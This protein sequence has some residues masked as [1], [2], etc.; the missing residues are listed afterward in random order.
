[1]A[2]TGETV[3]A[4]LT[5]LAIREIG[6]K[7]RSFLG[8]QLPIL[9][10]STPGNAQIL[11]IHTEPLREAL[12]RGE[13]P[14]VAGFQGIDAKGN[15]TTLGRGGS[16]TTAVAI[17]AALGNA[18]CE[19]YTDV[20]GVFTGDPKLVPTAQRIPSVSYRFMIEAAGL[21]AKVMHDR[22]VVIG[23]QYGVPIRVKS[24]FTQGFGTE[25]GS[26]ETHSRCVTS[27][28]VDP[29]VARVSLIGD[30][31]HSSTALIARTMETLKNRGIQCLGS[32]QGDLSFSSLV[33]ISRSV[34]TAQLFHSNYVESVCN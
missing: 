21:G 11:S 31:V 24:S 28:T 10:D 23:R 18:E 30:F 33:P 29:D 14:V 20:D 22:S 3:V 2:S 8:Y 16:D 32:S 13:I 12:K 17:A 19:I 27:V 34:E 15:I 25:I 6:G 9:T 5:S 1:V 4:A 7:A 26:K